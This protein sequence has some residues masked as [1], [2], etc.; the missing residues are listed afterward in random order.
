MELIAGA[1][2]FATNFTV[3][4]VAAVAVPVVFSVWRKFV[5]GAYAVASFCHDI[6]VRR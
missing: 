4:E 6:G 3:G 2:N 5:R 1:T